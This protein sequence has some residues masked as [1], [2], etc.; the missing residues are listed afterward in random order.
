MTTE[1]I[2]AAAAKRSFRSPKNAK[3]IR[4]LGGIL[5]VVVAW[6]ISVWVI[7]LPPYFYP[8]PSNVFD[9]F[10][11]LVERG[12]LPPYIGDSVGRYA[13]GVFCGTSIGVLIGLLIGLSRLMSA[14]LAPTINFFYSIVEVAWIP[15]FVIWWGYGIKTIIVALVYV[16]AF[17]VLYNTLI[18]VRTVPTVLI[19][20][21]KSLGATNLQ[22]LVNVILPSALPNIFTGFRIGA[23]FAFRGLIFAEMIAAQTG[24][25]YLIFEGANSQQTDRTI[26]GMITIGLM[27]LVI[28]RAY[29]S[30]VEKITI[31]RWG[32]VSD[33]K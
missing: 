4:Q 25:G 1:A 22:V 31:E 6:Q 13:L 7:D 16:A 12:I 15:L 17:P 27:W 32:L 30:P 3:R 29:L 11:E 10:I 5:A 20:A 2:P 23:G 28:D 14:V 8:G 9:A 24:V 21:S 19:N 18:G 26:V 33:S